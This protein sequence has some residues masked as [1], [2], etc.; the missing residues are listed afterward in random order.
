MKNFLKSAF[1]LT[2]ICCVMSIPLAHAQFDSSTHYEDAV[3]AILDEL[4]TSVENVSNLND[5]GAWAEQTQTRLPELLDEL[6]AAITQYSNQPLDDNSLTQLTI[7]SE[8]WNT[9]VAEYPDLAGVAVLVEPILD[10]ALAGLPAVRG[11]R[12]GDTPFQSFFEF[13]RAMEIRN[14]W[15]VSA[16]FQ[17][18]PL[19]N[20]T[21]LLTLVESARTQTF[22]GVEETFV[23]SS[24]TTVTVNNEVVFH[25]LII[26]NEVV[27]L[28]QKTV[29]VTLVHEI[30]RQIQQDG[31]DPSLVAAIQSL[32]DLIDFHLMEAQ[33]NGL[34]IAS[35]AVPAPAPANAAVN[36]PQPAVTQFL[37]DLFSSAHFAHLSELM[38]PF[39]ESVPAE[40]HGVPTEAQAKR[41]YRETVQV[42]PVES[43]KHKAEQPAK[44]EPVVKTK[45]VE[46]SALLDDYNKSS[47]RIGSL[48]LSI[49]FFPL[50]IGI[51]IQ[52]IKMA[53][54]P[55]VSLLKRRPDVY[56]R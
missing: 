1:S 50:F 25:Q 41:A 17:L 47:D 8:K 16:F 29:D 38:H 45:T 24:E 3:P 28:F 2:I 44:P 34:V 39:I 9:V 56:I 53:L 33:N 52:F 49:I 23:Y 22:K 13:Y 6:I 5:I 43:L 18:E 10:Q 7:L 11:H 37:E 51:L 42:V 55:T 21:R 54:S 35:A 26:D 48:W 14:P 12:A 30:L 15:G 32:V 36:V 19:P 40:T 31:L 20:I 4:T 27:K 46:T